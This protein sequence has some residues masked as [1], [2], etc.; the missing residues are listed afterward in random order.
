[1]KANLITGA[2]LTAGM[3]LGGIT[4]L[5]PNLALS[6]S[7]NPN[8]IIGRWTVVGDINPTTTTLNI[9]Q[10]ANG[11]ISGTIF[12]NPLQGVYIPSSR[13][14]VFVRIVN[15]VP[16]QFYQGWLSANGLRLAGQINIWN[17]SGG[18]ITTGTVDFNFSATK[19]SDLPN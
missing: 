13:R 16:V 9:T 5:S 3:M 2:A 12:G 19:V 10:S 15:G 4:M 17:S 18:S 7:A 1:M 14:I 11:T 8:N 6:Q